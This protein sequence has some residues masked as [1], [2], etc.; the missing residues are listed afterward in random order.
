MRRFLRAFEQPLLRNELT[1]HAVRRRTYVVPI[2][3]PGL[4][5]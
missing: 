2:L 4:L 3:Y 1:E 5:L